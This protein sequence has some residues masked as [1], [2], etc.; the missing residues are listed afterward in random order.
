[1]KRTLSL[2]RETLTELSHEQ[3]TSVVGGAPPTTP[4]KECLDDP[5]YTLQATRCF[6]P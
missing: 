6:C 5:F 3:L 1:M 4:V 2:K